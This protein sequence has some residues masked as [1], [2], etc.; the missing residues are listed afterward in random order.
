MSGRLAI[1]AL[2]L[3][4]AF[5][6]CADAS[7][8]PRA[9][10]P[11]EAL[12][13][14]ASIVRPIG[15]PVARGVEGFT[16]IVD[17]AELDDGRVLLTDS[18]E[19]SMAL[20][21][22]AA[23]TVERIGRIGQGPVEY[24]SVSTILPREDGSFAVYDARQHRLTLLSADGRI[25]G[26]EGIALPPFTG[27]S[28]PRGPDADGWVYVDAR[29]VGPNGLERAAPLFRW[30]V[31]TG[32]T[33]SL[34]LVMQYAEG[35]EGSGIV[36]MPKGD[37]WS[38]LL[39]GSVAR[40]V[41]EDYHVEWS[42]GGRDPV[43]GSP[44]PH[45]NTLVGPAERRRWVEMM[46]SRPAGRVSFSGDSEAVSSQEVDRRLEEFGPR[47][48]PEHLPAFSTGYAP[49]SPQGHVWLRLDVESGPERTVLDVIDR[50]GRLVRR[51]GVRGR[52]RVVGFGVDAV[53]LAR[54][55]SQDLEWLEKFPYP[56]DLEG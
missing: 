10:G 31:R 40:I 22:L 42:G 27:F 34:M 41:G 25:S 21:D 19:R 45:A 55:D 52:A 1:S 20:V 2:A 30:N 16:N 12:E 39:D 37:A 32:A 8:E 46:L 9:S 28:A 15:E 13:R 53:Y 5:A 35:Q 29:R 6:S 47:R 50:D 24:M 51:L 7:P 54:K 36:P 43:V 49:A 17:V 11:G 18:R 14:G 33:D 4:G 48:F 26:T 3:S 56:T 38:F 23:R 44:V